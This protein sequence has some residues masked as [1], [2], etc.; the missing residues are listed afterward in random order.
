MLAKG[1][2]KPSV[3]PYSSPVLFV[4]KKIGKLQ[5]CIDFHALNANM[6]LNVFLLPRIADL[7]DRLYKAKYFSSVYLA[8]AYH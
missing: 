7:L 6:K 3:S 8:T 5:I 1:W 2:I 4:Q